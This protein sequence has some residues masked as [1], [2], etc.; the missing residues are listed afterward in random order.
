M[1]ASTPALNSPEEI[2]LAPSQSDSQRP[3][4]GANVAK[5]QAAFGRMRRLGWIALAYQ[6]GATALLG[7]LVG[8][9]QA[10]KTELLEN[11]L[12]AVPII[13][14][15]IAHRMESKGQ[16][17]H[18][19]FGYHR[20]ATIIFVAAAFTLAGMGA[21]L[22]FDSASVLWRHEHPEIKNI[23]LFGQTVWMGWLMM[24]AMAITG[25][26]P[27]ILGRFQAPLAILLHDKPL[28]ACAEMNRANALTNGAGVLGLLMVANGLWW[29]DA[30]A[31][32]LISFDILRDG[33][34]NISR[35]LSD[36][37]D[38]TPVDLETNRQCPSVAQ[39]HRAVKALPFVADY[40]VL[41]REH[42]RFFFAEVFIC[43]N[44]QMPDVLEATRQV[45]EALLPLD[46]RLQH[47]AVEFTHDVSA[48]SQVP[49]QQ[50]YLFESSAKT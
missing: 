30:I 36:V 4:D 29:G 45:R 32:L 2:A 37:M 25:I 26:A 43:P 14:L 19:P 44:A 38:R 34:I 13:G 12:G 49:S 31:A 35:S 8:G 46:W 20:A 18:R 6:I 33:W 40:R 9:S 1:P 39:V 24:G 50:E 11:L 22:L 41:M 21:Y 7:S 16:D 27:V 5:L 28:H 23:V 17:V 3:H 42:G 47:I 48:A 15:L 10:M